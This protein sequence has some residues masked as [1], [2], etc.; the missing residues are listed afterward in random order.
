MEYFVN[1]MLLCTGTRRRCVVEAVVRAVVV[2]L[3]QMETYC[4]EE[5]RYTHGFGWDI[6]GSSGNA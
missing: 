2:A 4:V 1:F 3:L 5:L 6:V